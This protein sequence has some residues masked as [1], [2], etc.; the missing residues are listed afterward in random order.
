MR[1]RAA[2]GSVQ[3]YRLSSRRCAR[4][5]LPRQLALVGMRNVARREWKAPALR[6]ALRG[7]RAHASFHPCACLAQGS[8]ERICAVAQRCG[9]ACAVRHT[10]GCACAKSRAVFCRCVCAGRAVRMRATACRAAVAGRWGCC[11][12]VSGVGKGIIRQAWLSCGIS[13]RSAKDY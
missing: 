13:P 5:R 12:S 3:P 7:G 4:T 9:G 6:R 2:E 10:Y 1:V 11:S 8:A